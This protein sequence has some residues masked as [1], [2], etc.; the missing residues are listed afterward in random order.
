MNT[1]VEDLTALIHETEVLKRY[2]DLFADRELRE[3]RHAGKIEFYDLRKGPHYTL[4]QLWAYLDSRKVKSCANEL[5]P[6]ERSEDPPSVPAKEQPN[7]SSRLTPSGSG[8]RTGATISSITG[9]TKPLEE[10]AARQLENE[11]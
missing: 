6:P 9:M 10:R 2:K 3:A 5:L 7:G 4:E 8:A 11:T 1:E